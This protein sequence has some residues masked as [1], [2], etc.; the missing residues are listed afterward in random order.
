MA[1]ISDKPWSQFSASDYTLEQ[2]RRACLIDLNTGSPSNATKGNLK[3]PVREPDGTRNRTGIIAAGNRLAGAGGGVQ[4]PPAAK[5]AAARALIGLYAQ[6][7]LSPPD[8][9]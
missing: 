2:D 1:S 4:A 6:I 5:R 3:L 8:S 9:V 7:K